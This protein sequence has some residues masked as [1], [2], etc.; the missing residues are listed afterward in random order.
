[1]NPSETYQIKMNRCLEKSISRGPCRSLDNRFLS[2]PLNGNAAV[3]VP[4]AHR[5]T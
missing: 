3:Q 5:S 4:L 2:T 1:M